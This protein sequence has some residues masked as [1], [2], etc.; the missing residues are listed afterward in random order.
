MLSVPLV[1]D[2]P[3]RTRLFIFGVAG[4]WCCEKNK[5]GKDGERSL[6]DERSSSVMSR[7]QQFNLSWGHQ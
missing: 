3:Q 6:L 7:W 2:T 1:G 5:G 4:G